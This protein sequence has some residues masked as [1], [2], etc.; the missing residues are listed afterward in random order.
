MQLLP[1]DTLAA[2]IVDD[3]L[4]EIAL[5]HYAAVAK[6]L[7][8]NISEIYAAK[9]R[10]AS[11]SPRPSEGFSESIITQ[12]LIPDVVVECTPQQELEVAMYRSFMP[13]LRISK[14]YLDIYKE[15]G[16]EKVREYLD[17]K[18]KSA[19]QLINSISQ[20]EKSILACANIIVEEQRDFFLNVSQSMKPLSQAHV[21]HRMGVSVS[22]VSR[23]T[24]EKYIQCSRGIIPMKQFFSR[25]VDST[26]GISADQVK[27]NLVSLIQGENRA[28][29]YS[30]QQLCDLLEQ[31]GIRI[32]RRTVAKYRD[33]LN[34]PGTYARK[35]RE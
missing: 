13:Y 10:I 34:I 24:T 14:E 8:K 3:Y 25:E 26:E 9:E 6:A 4:E 5:G 18:L 20:R 27:E 11:L 31:R 19:E 16:D 28:K 22:T 35:K 12:Y 29:P 15:T 30:D 17:S 23:I 1:E 7:S 33:L 2:S 21:A 32:S